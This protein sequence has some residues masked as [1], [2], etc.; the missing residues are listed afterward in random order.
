MHIKTCHLAPHTFF[1]SRS[2]ETKVCRRGDRCS[3]VKS[4]FCVSLSSNAFFV[5]ET[6]TPVLAC[7][8]ITDAA[9]PLEAEVY[10]F[11]RR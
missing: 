1:Y 2:G 6:S 4:A 5:I 11:G 8:V 9:P 7:T 3:Q 10:F